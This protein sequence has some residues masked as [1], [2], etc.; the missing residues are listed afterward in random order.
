MKVEDKRV[1]FDR[2]VRHE[3]VAKTPATFELQARNP[4]AP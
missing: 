1:R 3:Q 4:P 2:D